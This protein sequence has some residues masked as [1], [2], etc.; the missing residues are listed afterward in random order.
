MTILSKLR[1]P[2]HAPR[3]VP[4]PDARRELV[5]AATDCDAAALGLIE[6]LERRRSAITAAIAAGAIKPALGKRMLSREAVD[7]AFHAAGLCAHAGTPRSGSSHRIGFAGQVAQALNPE[8][9]N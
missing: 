1:P 5:E 4:A 9:G 2:V 6:C 7:R 3:R 8:K